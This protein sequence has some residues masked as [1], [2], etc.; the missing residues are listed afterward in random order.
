MG[1]CMTT[2]AVV[3]GLGVLAGTEAEKGKRQENGPANEKGQHEPVDEAQH[4]IDETAML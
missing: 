1:R 3:I 2:H 4:V